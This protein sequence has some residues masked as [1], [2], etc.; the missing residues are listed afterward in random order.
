MKLDELKTFG[1]SGYYDVKSQLQR[2]IYNRSEKAFAAGDL[3][4]DAITSTRALKLRQEF[5]RKQFIK[6]IGRLP[7]W[8][9]DLNAKVVGTVTEN[10]LRIEKIIFQSRPNVFVTA[11]LY[12]PDKIKKPS[13]AVLFLCGH[14]Q[15]AKH[16][17]EYQIV[18]RHMA[19]AGLIV[20]AQDPVGQGERLSYYEQDINASTIQWGV[21]EHDYAGQQCLAVGDSIAKYFLH[22]AMRG[23]DYLCS[24]TEVDPKRIGVTG[25]SGGG[26][27]TCMMMLADRRIAA[28]APGTFVMNRQ[29]YMYTGGA[30]DAE[31]IWPGLS[32]QGIDHED[33][34]LSMAPRPVRVLAVKYDFFPIEGTRRTV[35]RCKR[36]WKMHDC[37]E[38]LD[39]VEDT[40]VHMYTPRLARSAAEFFAKHLLGKKKLA[41]DERT[42]KAIAPEKL[43]CTRSG[44]VR[45]EIPKARFVFEENLDRV[46]ELRK[47]PAKGSAQHRN[48]ALT[49]LAEQVYRCRGS[50]EINPRIYCSAN[51]EEI[52]FETAFWFS[53]TD[54]INSGVLFRHLH[55]K[56]VLHV[57]IALWNGGTTNIAEHF[58]WIRSTCAENR[59]VLVLDVTGMGQLEPNPLNGYPPR[60]SYGVIH[61][62]SDDLVWLD[63]SLAAMRTYDVIR[64]VDVLKFW[65]GL[66]SNGVY[67]YACDRQGV[68]GELAAAIDKRIRKIKTVKNMLSYASWVTSRHY[69]S[70]DAR[71]LIIPGMLKYCDLLDIRKWNGDVYHR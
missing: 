29:S 10:R 8:K 23:I 35:K 41:I 17:P 55:N 18:C 26:T 22:D 67:V 12:I 61:K 52:R 59:A 2:H 31:Q 13:A 34:I 56:S 1:P 9:G 45:G 32:A 27:Q 68:Y 30:Q 42:I 69:D 54:I 53:Q 37:V 60:A 3:A 39:I 58:D 20:L 36:F 16:E 51:I 43:W 63:D 62:F 25:N 11:D 6:C 48:K 70:F 57:T 65:P 5:I 33:I 21:A 50:G 28:A 71:S 7:D 49:W 14:H 40:S 4:R 46:K 64:A 24:R 38:C 44:N 15:Q 66:D 19:A 47:R